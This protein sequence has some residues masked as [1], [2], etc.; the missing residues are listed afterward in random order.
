MVSLAKVKESIIEK[1]R[2]IIKVI[3]YGV[4]TAKQVAPY[5]IDSTPLENLTAIYCESE[6]DNEAIIIGYINKNHITKKGEIRI[7]SDSGAYVH[8]KDNGIVDINGNDYSAVRYQELNLELQKQISLLNIELSK[9]ATAGATIG[10]IYAPTLLQI[11]LTQSES[12]T[13]RLK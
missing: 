8:C 10:M 11:D 6:N 4:K 7:Y 3:Q 9:I 1:S 12:S 2:R 5:G 13:V